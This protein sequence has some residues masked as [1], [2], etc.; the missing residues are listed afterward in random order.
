MYYA[1][2]CTDKPHGTELRDATRSTHD[3]F[4]NALGDRLVLAGPFLDDHGTPT[5]SLIVI[6]ANNRD[7]ALAVTEEDPYQRAGL[8]E[9]V[10]IRPWYWKFKNPQG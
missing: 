5:G 6:E 4:L 7:E 1:L 8:F 2:I 3:E 9:S 10:E